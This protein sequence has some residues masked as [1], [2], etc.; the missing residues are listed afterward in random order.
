MK[1]LPPSLSVALLSLLLSEPMFAQNYKAQKTTDHGV[2][3]VR[4]TDTAKG[5]EVSIAP[6]IGNRAYEM[7][8]HGKNILYLG[9]ADVG[10]LKQR[11]GLSGIP[12][13]APWA[14]RMADG[15][16]WAGDKK[17]TFNGQLGSVRLPANGVAIHGMPTAAP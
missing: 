17:Y 2:D 5:V 15:G 3:I 7:K 4:L 14:N 1:S 8:V 9:A 6:S 10:A 11:A 16:F 13:L 12:F